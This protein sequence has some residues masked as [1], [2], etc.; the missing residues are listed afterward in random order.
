VNDR[1]GWKVETVKSKL[2]N[3]NSALVLGISL[4]M[5]LGCS[6]KYNKYTY[7]NYKELKKPE[8]EREL[9]STIVLNE[10]A[11]NR[12][13]D[14]AVIK[15][16]LILV[17]YKAD[18]FIKIFSIRSHKVVQSFGLHGQ[19]P[20]EFVQPSE[21]IPSSKDKNM[22]WIY[23]LSTKQLKKYN[24]NRILDNEFK[25]DSIIRLKGENGFNIHFVITPDDKIL[26][27]GFYADGRFNIFNLDG[28]LIRTIGKIPVKVKNNQFA[29]SHSHGFTGNFI[30]KT[31][32]KEIFIATRLGS[33]VEKYDMQGNLISTFY[34]PDTFFPEYD[35]VPT[36]NNYYTMTYNRKTRFGFLDI[37][38]CD[39]TDRLFLLYS[40]KY[41]EGGKATFGGGIIYVLNNRGIITE[42]LNLDKTLYEIK[43]SDD[44]STLFGLTTKNEIV[45]FE[46]GKSANMKPGKVNN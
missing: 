18:K 25:P 43:I 24:L 14:F 20:S 5:I 31:K 9:S 17:D 23:D 32:T 11:V 42:Q 38:Y 45:A 37:S 34:G 36:V 16:Y 44:G 39:K 1:S 3:R 21:I 22:F 10:D 46:Y 40:G 33:I 26:A 7:T 19:G 27:T 4:L 6:G 13:G 15:N 28:D 8:Q 2:L 35:I 29:T 30:Y 41:F 12:A